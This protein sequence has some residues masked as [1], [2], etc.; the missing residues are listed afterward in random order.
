MRGLRRGAGSL[1]TRPRGDGEAARD[2]GSAGGADRVEHGLRD[3]VRPD[4]RRERLTVDFDV[5][6]IGVLLQRNHFLI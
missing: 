4:Q 2:E 3:V 5:D 1:R 6:A